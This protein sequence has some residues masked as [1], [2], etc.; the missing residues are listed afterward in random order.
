MIAEVEPARDTR[1]GAASYGSDAAQSLSLARPIDWTRGLP[2]LHGPGLTLREPCGDDATALVGMLATP[3][4][5]RFMNRSPGR[6]GAF[7][8][9]IRWTRRQRRLGQ[10]FCYGIVPDGHEHPV[11]LIQVRQTEPGFGAAEW[12]FAIG[13]PF[14]GRDVF[15]RAGRM[16]IDFIF[17]NT[18][19]HR[20]EARTAIQNG[21]ANGALKKLGATPEGVLRESFLIDGQPVH[22]VLWSLRS[23]EWPLGNSPAPYRVELVPDE[24]ESASGS[25]SAPE[26]TSPTLPDWCRQVPESRRAGV[27]LRELID[28]D[29]E[30]L[31]RLVSTPDIGRYMLPP[32]RTVE[33]FRHFIAWSHAQRAAGLYACMGVVPDA[34][35][36]AV[37]I[38]QLHRVDQTF[39]IAEWGFALG[40][41]YWGTGLFTTGARMFLDFA[42]D[43]VGV[44][45]L[46][47]R[48]AQANVRANAALRKLGAAR[49]GAMRRSFLL[50]G[51]YYD[52]YLWSLLAED[53]NA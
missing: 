11:G 3:E 39:N 40:K 31:V 20:L 33:A 47:A 1:S 9:F 50:G 6:A 27:R 28:S 30:P 35:D 49:E 25:V 37:G 24:P 43:T 23:E 41:P 38:F 48:A 17:R 19:A 2:V 21:R 5:G 14:W 45:R 4:V 52:D 8:A 42:F 44:R 13:Q 12:G 15:P 16:A 18:G 46:E 29:A 53:R 7:K 36:H 26:P 34:C 32:P 51:E 10:N 22:Q